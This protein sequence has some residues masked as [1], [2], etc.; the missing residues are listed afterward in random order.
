MQ[1]G[2]NVGKHQ[3]KTSQMRK[4]APFVAIRFFDVCRHLKQVTPQEWVLNPFSQWYLRCY[5]GETF[6]ICWI[7]LPADLKNWDFKKRR[8]KKGFCLTPLQNCSFLASS[9]TNK[10]IVTL[11]LHSASVDYIKIMIN[12]VYVFFFIFCDRQSENFQLM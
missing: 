11:K 1:L 2:L 4:Q 6:F 10:K 12:G 9:E 5:L 7:T 3:R 8:K